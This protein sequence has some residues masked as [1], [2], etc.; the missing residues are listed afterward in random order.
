MSSTEFLSPSRING[1]LGYR[2]FG[3]KPFSSSK[4]NISD[5]NFYKKQTLGNTM[6]W[7]NE[8][9]N[10]KDLKV[11]PELISGSPKKL[12]DVL[13]KTIERSPH[14]DENV[15]N[16]RSNQRNLQ[17]KIDIYLGGKQARSE[18]FYGWKLTNPNQKML[19][20]F[21][22]L[23]AAALKR[24]D[25]DIQNMINLGGF[26][27]YNTVYPEIESVTI[28]PKQFDSFA[29]LTYFLLDKIPP[30]ARPLLNNVTNH[31]RHNRT[32]AFSRAFKKK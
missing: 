30:N 15:K 29:Q 20:A 2:G 23:E 26:T 32:D 25:P 13:M 21:K 27:W 1:K 31:Q 14:V 28:K 8:K 9:Y 11:S 16:W 18:A 10:I 12:I 6:I 4:V 17:T 7:T 22:N 19:H 24:S 5:A 3:L